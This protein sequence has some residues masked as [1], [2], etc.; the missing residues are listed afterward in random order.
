MN[1]KQPSILK[2]I[3]MDFWAMISTIF[4]VVSPALYFYLAYTEEN[5]S[6]QPAWILWGLFA[7]AIFGLA[8]RCISIFSLFN[9]GLEARATISEI[10]FF[11]DR[12]FIKY[13]Y[14]FQGQK[15]ASQMRVMKNRTTT[16]YQIGDEVN[17][18]VD[19]ENPRKSIIRDL[20]V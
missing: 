13:V 7:L 6:Q 15:Y 20:F 9:G 2:I 12:G 8:S 5:F 11:R 1:D 3:W 18:I 10:G 19:R 4:V 16:S 14:S 17:V